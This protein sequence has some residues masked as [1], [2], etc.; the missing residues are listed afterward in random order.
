MTK[1]PELRRTESGLAVTS[2]TLAV[3]RDFSGKGQQKEV[4]FIDCVAWKHNAEFVEKYFTKG[5]QAVVT[6]RLQIRSYKD[7]NENTRKVAE[8][9]VESIYFAGGKPGTQA[10]DNTEGAPGAYAVIVEEDAELPF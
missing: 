9:N 6:G 7:K 8:V 3:D 4:D 1:A 5:S 10:V 2:F